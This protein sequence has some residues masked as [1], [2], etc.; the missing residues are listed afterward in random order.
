[1]E[2]IPKWLADVYL[3]LF[4]VF[5]TE[6]FST[7]LAKHLFEDD[8]V[9]LKALS[10]LKMKGWITRVKKGRY[11]LIDLKELVFQITP[12]LSIENVEEKVRERKKISNEYMINLSFEIHGLGGLPCT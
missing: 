7:Q 1:M 11:K 10:E 12:E 9:F 8:Q 6:E 5:G 3:K 2:W 4:S